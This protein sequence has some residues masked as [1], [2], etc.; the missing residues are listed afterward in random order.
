MSRLTRIG[1]PAQ[2]A[3]LRHLS[4]FEPLSHQDYAELTGM[5]PTGAFARLRQAWDKKL[6]YIHSWKRGFAG[7]PV[8]LY[9]IGSLPDAP[10]METLTK[11]EASQRYRAKKDAAVLYAKGRKWTEMR[12]L[13]MD[14]DPEY[15]K[16]ITEYRREWARRKFGYAPKSL[17]CPKQLQAIA[18][19]FGITWR[20]AA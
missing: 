2:E 7:A 3:V 15:R 5:K 4:E 10:K 20:K 17:T 13:K 8:P 16:R 12:Q 11:T 18:E 19:Q 6:V 14:S 1:N 9:A